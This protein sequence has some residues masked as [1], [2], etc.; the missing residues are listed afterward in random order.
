MNNF[1]AGFSSLINSTKELV[2]DEKGV[3]IKVLVLESEYLETAETIVTYC[4]KYITEEPF[5]PEIKFHLF[6]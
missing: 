5:I 2:L 1:G 4:K 3:K 6:G